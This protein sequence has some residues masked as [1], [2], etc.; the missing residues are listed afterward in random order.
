[1]NF[2]TG[3]FAKYE[4]FIRQTEQYYALPRNL[5]AVTLWQASQF[6]PVKIESKNRNSIG[7][8]GIAALTQRDIQMLWNGDDRRRDPFASI[9]GA[10]RLLAAYKS[11]FSNWRLALLAYHCGANELREALH[12]DTRL[13]IDARRY[14][15]EAQSACGV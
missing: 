13:P 10:A 2:K 1:M 5:L 7:I 11:Q 8:I 3:D 15:D 14:A 4:S 9:V 12:M 6:D